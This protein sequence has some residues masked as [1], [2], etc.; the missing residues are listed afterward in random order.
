[1][2]ANGAVYLL[3]WSPELTHKMYVG[4]TEQDPDA[5]E[6]YWDHLSIARHV[7]KRG[8]KD[9]LHNAIRK[10]GPPE[11]VVLFR[12]AD[13]RELYLIEIELIAHYNTLA[14]HG[15]NLRTGGQGGRHSLET[16][17]KIAEAQKVVQ[18]RP[19]VREAKRIAV[20]GDRNPS[21][22][23]EVRHKL[24]ERQRAYMATPEGVETQTIGNIVASYNRCARAAARDCAEWN[25]R[26]AELFADPSYLANVEISLRAHA[27]R[28]EKREARK[29]YM[30]EVLAEDIGD[31]RTVRRPAR[32][33]ERE[34]RHLLDRAV[35]L[36]RLN[37]DGTVSRRAVRADIRRTSDMVASAIS[38][39][40]SRAE[41]AAMADRIA[42]AGSMILS[43][44]AAHPS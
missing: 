30:R 8:R 20:L 26:D 25:A 28:R 17:Q 27:A 14:P 39:V 42:A 12:S 2:S 1:M 21:K 41:I 18:A 38:A 35:N 43:H 11:L 16:R 37:G 44:Q 22:R 31:R 19:E 3:R 9:A 36:A 32:R 7:H 34:Y 33:A 6:R 10:Y 24:S 5:R 40:F 23:P 13:P 15:Y 4:K 29:R